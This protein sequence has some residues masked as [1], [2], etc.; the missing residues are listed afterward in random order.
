MQITHI[1]SHNPYF[2]SKEFEDIKDAELTDFALALGAAVTNE[3]LFPLHTK[4]KGIYYT[5]GN[6]KYDTYGTTKSMCN[7]D[8]LTDRHALCFRPVVKL[9]DEEL[10]YFLMD[11]IV[12]IKNNKYIV[13]YSKF[14][15]SA[16][17]YNTQ[18]ILTD[19]WNQ[20][21]LNKVWMFSL[22]YGDD[23]HIDNIFS[24]NGEEYIL[25]NVNPFIENKKL[26]LS[27]GARY[28][29]NALV[30]I[31]IEPI[32]WY[33]FGNYLVSEKLLIS[34]IP[35]KPFVSYGREHHTIEDYFKK[36]ITDPITH[37]HYASNFINEDMKYEFLHNKSQVLMG[38]LNKYNGMSGIII[39]QSVKKIIGPFN[40]N[41]S[42]S[43][44]ISF[45]KNSKLAIIEDYAFTRGKQN[46]DKTNKL[47]NIT[48]P[49]KINY[50]GDCAFKNVC[51]NLEIKTS[52]FAT[53]AD[54]FDYC[55]SARNQCLQET[56]DLKGKTRLKIYNTI[57]D[58]DKNLIDIF[59]DIQRREVKDIITYFL[60]VFDLD[61]NNSFDKLINEVLIKLERDK[62]NINNRDKYWLT[63]LINKVLDY[64]FIKKPFLGF[65]TRGMYVEKLKDMLD[66]FYE[67]NTLEYIPKEVPK[68]IILK[69]DIFKGKQLSDIKKELENYKLKEININD[70]VS[71]MEYG[72]DLNIYLTYISNE[73]GPNILQNKVD[74]EEI[75]EIYEKY[76]SIK[77]LN[78]LTSDHLKVLLDFISSKANSCDKKLDALKNLSDIMHLYI[79]RLEGVKNYLDTLFSSKLNDVASDAKLAINSIYA[80]K[81]GSLNYMYVSATEEYEQILM[82]IAEIYNCKV[83]FSKL[84]NTTLPKLAVAINSSDESSKEEMYKEI[85]LIF[86]NIMETNEE[87]KKKVKK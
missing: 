39:P 60:N 11:K 84:Q 43:L 33:L 37:Y 80:D 61:Y 41:H 62:T 27:N 49:P 19:L 66:T 83:S 12:T 14:P 32:K 17:D 76:L 59:E 2:E 36:V 52:L 55:Y 26:M 23:W 15:Q 4:R 54:F 25:I 21:E 1:D 58:D 9:H 57:I 20:N 53:I 22:Y 42:P 71:L 34:G 79:E 28:K 50:I 7:I 29:K 8:Y 68:A 45:E 56:F 87:S 51:C 77:S 38:F 6:L 86:E 46:I 31:K 35:Y 48:I 63:F 44:N 70:F 13:E 18:R 78:F 47:E 65:S 16:A 64:V 67:N 40:N 69:N 75:E 5:Y 72:D 81:L 82:M 30:W 74:K 73:I 3:S 24:Y 10:S 85:N